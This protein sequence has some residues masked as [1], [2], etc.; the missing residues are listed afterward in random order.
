MARSVQFNWSEPEQPTEAIVTALSLATG[1]DPLDIEPL[2]ERIDGD[3]LNSLLT[4]SG[5][6]QTN[7][8]ISFLYDGYTVIVTGNGEV[9]VE[10]R[11]REATND[12]R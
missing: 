6:N 10:S 4:P 3:A 11:K 5:D 2:H 1:C 9:T 12:D 7:L 8:R